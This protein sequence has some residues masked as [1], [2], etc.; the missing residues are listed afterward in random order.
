M[1][2]TQIIML[3]AIGGTHFSLRPGQLVSTDEATAQRMFDNSLA[4]KLF[5]S[6]PTEEQ[7]AHEHHLDD[8]SP[9]EPEAPKVPAAPAT[10]AKPKR[11]AKARQEFLPKE[12]EASKVPAESP[13]QGTGATADA[14]TTGSE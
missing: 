3:Q 1:A 8:E 4:R 7:L 2:K 14:G 5:K 9:A 13:A 12:P 11:G 10:P 6:E